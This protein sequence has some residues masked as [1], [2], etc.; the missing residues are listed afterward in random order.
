MYQVTIKYQFLKR[1]FDIFFALFGIIIFFLPVL[2]FGILIKII[3]RGPVLHWSERLGKNN[4]CFKM[5]KL[6]TMENGAPMLSS[7]HFKESEKYLIKCG[8]MIRSSGIDELPQLY[9]I[10]KGD[11][12]FVGPRP[13]IRDD[14]EVIQM[15]IKGSISQIKPGLTGLAQ[16]N[17]RSELTV[18]DKVYYDE[19]Y[20]EKMCF[21]LDLKILIYTNY[22]LFYENVLK[23]IIPKNRLLKINYRI[24]PD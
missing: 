13:V 18:L 11:M 16:I 3:S 7:T 22:Y 24:I 4:I 21:L 10:L 14:N 23:K 9:N 5:V 15:R 19:I 17:G 20:A 2:L 8:K 6:R 12:S 1:L